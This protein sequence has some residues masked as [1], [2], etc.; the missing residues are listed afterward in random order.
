MSE[1]LMTFEELS[2]N[3]FL[4]ENQLVEFCLPNV[5][6]CVGEIMGTSWW[7]RRHI[8]KIQIVEA[9]SWDPVT[10]AWKWQGAYFIQFAYNQF[11]SFIG[12]YETDSGDIFFMIGQQFYV[13][14][15]RKNGKL[16]K[17]LGA[18]HF[19]ALHCRFMEPD[20]SQGKTP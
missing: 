20:P 14:I 12:P 1:R 4:L 6:I 19:Y 2:G 10:G 5:G 18:A 7:P 15:F 3:M 8:R 17:P 16:E 13:R 11:E 9:R